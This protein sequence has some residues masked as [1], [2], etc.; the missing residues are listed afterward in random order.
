MQWGIEK[1]PKPNDLRRV[2]RFAWMPEKV[3][4][5][6]GN[7]YVRVWL[8]YVEDLQEYRRTM[9]GYCWITLSTYQRSVV[10]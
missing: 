7:S 4:T 5:D 10:Q 8:D 2:Q 6:D 9:H 1:K 3:T